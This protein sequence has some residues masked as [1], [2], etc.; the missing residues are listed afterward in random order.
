M[1]GESST[2]GSAPGPVLGTCSGCIGEKEGTASGV[3][4]SG[5]PPNSGK[6]GAAPAL[7][8]MPLKEGNENAAACLPA[9]AIIGLFT[10]PFAITGNA[11]MVT[12]PV[13]PAR[14]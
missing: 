14:V 1:A 12:V 3:N 8:L 9:W 5:P 13:A 4:V 7:P 10:W 11:E 2:P 6:E